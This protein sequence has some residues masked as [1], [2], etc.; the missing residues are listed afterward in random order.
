MGTLRAFCT[1]CTVCTFLVA[2]QTVHGDFCNV[3]KP[4]RPTS[5]QIDAM[6]DAQVKE[7]LAH[8]RKGAAL[9]AWKP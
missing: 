3:A 6:T 9:C 5:E 8:N 7:L 4:I 1:I 2:C